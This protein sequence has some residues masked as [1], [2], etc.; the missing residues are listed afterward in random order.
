MRNEVPK[1]A[2]D[3]LA[4]HAKNRLGDDIYCTVFENRLAVVWPRAYGADGR[5]KEIEAFAKTHGWSVSI[6]DPGIRITFKKLA[7]KAEG[8]KA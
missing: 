3:E 8:N 5:I 2:S 4:K 1:L 6:A 7:K